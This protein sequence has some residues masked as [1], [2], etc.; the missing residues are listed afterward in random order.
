MNDMV[1]REVQ[2]LGVRDRLVTILGRTMQI[3]ERL[4]SDKAREHM[5]HGLARRLRILH[6][7]LSKIVAVAFAR[8][9]QPLSDDEE[10]NLTLH[11]NSFYLHIRGSLDN[12]AWCLVYELQLFG[13]KPREEAVLAQVNLFHKSFLKKLTSVA[14]DLAASVRQHEE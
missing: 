1:S 5:K 7:G 11:L 2:A 3:A 12:L 8:R 14:P 6:L 9:E 4:K 10:L 13:A